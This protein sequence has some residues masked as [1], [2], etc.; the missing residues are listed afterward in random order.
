ME[1]LSLY[2]INIYIIV[3]SLINQCLKIHAGAYLI[4]SLAIS[5]VSSESYT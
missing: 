2:N 5:A 3:A 1:E 4:I